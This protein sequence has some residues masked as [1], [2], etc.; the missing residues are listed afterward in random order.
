MKILSNKIIHLV[1]LINSKKKQIIKI[2]IKNSQYKIFNKKVK[3][4]LIILVINQ[5]QVLNK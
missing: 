2:L 5:V 3:Y 1:N 4:N